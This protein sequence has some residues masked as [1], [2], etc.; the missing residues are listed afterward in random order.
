LLGNLDARRDWGWAPDYVD[1]M[2]R[3]L[4]APTARDWILGTGVS[5]SVRDLCRAAYGAVGLDW[6]AYVQVDPGLIRPAEIDALVGDPS[7]L[8]VALGWR[9]TV[10]FDDMIARMVQAALDEPT[11]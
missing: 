11:R 7:E 8:T 6:Q 9:P 3:M 2:W 10:G 4:Q 1:A 5:R